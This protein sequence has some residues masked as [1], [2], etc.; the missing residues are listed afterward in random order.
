MISPVSSSIVASFGASLPSVNFVP[1]GTVVSFPSLSLTIGFTDVSSPTFPVAS[2]Y[3]GA[4]LSESVSTFSYWAVN[5]IGWPDNI[6]S[7]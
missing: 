3:S 4:Y 6:F 7:V 5:V 1:S 2:L